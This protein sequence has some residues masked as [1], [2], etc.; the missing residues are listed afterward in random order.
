[1]AIAAADTKGACTRTGTTFSCT[2]ATDT[3]Q[4]DPKKPNE[5][6]FLFKCGSSVSLI[7]TADGKPTGTTGQ[8]SVDVEVDNC[9]PTLALTDPQK[10][11]LD[12]R[13]YIGKFDVIG[14]VAEK[15]F[16][17]AS[18]T[19]RLDQEGAEP[20]E[21]LKL[22]KPGAFKHTID[23]RFD[24]SAHWI[25][26]LDSTDAVGNGS[27]VEA[28]VRIVRQPTF[29]GNS[30]ESDKFLQKINDF[31]IDQFDPEDTLLDALVATPEGLVLRRGLPRADDPAVHGGAFDPLAPDIAL[32]AT[33]APLLG[34]DGKIVD[35]AELHQAPYRILVG[36]VKRLFVEDLD[37]D[38]D[39]DVIA[40]GIDAVTG[41][42][43]WALLAWDKT[44]KTKDG[45]KT[46]RTFKVLDKRSLPEEPLSAAFADLDKDGAKDL[47]VGAK[48]DN[49]GLSVVRLQPQ[50]TCKAKKADAAVPCGELD[51][52]TITIGTIF[53]ELEAPVVNKGVTQ[54]TSIAVGDYYKDDKSLPDVCVGE[55]TR[56]VI[57]CYRN[58][59]VDGRLEQ[60]QDGLVLPDYADTT[61]IVPVEWSAPGTN[62]GPDLIV[63]TTKG[64]RWLKGKHDGT[65]FYDPG[66]Y[67]QIVGVNATAVQVAPIGPKGSPYLIVTAAGREVTVLP[68]LASDSS[69]MAMCFR[70]WVLGGAVGAA[71]AVDLDGNGAQD[72]VSIDAAPNGVNVAWGLP[73]GEYA[74]PNAYH[75]CARPENT[76]ALAP[77]ELADFSFIDLGTDKFPELL[78]IGKSSWSMQP[79]S[80]GTCVLEG[81]GVIHKPAWPISIYMNFNKKLLPTPRGGE[82]A[83]YAHAAQSGASA[84]CGQGTI[85]SFGSVSALRA[86]DLT[87]DKIADLALTRD[88]A[89]Y[90]IGD[91]TVSSPACGP[92]EWAA[93]NEVDN[94]FGVDSPPAPAAG[95]PELPKQLCCKNFFAGDEKKTKP[96]SGYGSGA[97]LQRASLFLFQGTDKDPFA[98][99]PA[100][101]VSQPC[102]IKPQV[103]LAAG[104]N[105]IGIATGDF[106]SDKRIDLA[107]VMK[108]SG[109]VSNEKQ[110]YLEARV[111]YFRSELA[112][113]KLTVQTFKHVPQKDQWK[114]ID[115]KSG[116][117]AKNIDVTYR[118]VEQ[119]PFD[120]CVAPWGPGLKLPS[121]FT[122]NG[123]LGHV[124]VVRSVGNL[125]T[126]VAKEFVI[127]AGN[128]TCVCDDF[129]GDAWMDLLCA[130]PSSI[131]FIRGDGTLF[132]P[133][134]T[135]TEDLEAD[136]GALLSVD[137]NKDDVPDIAYID[138]QAAVVEF[139]LGTGAP[140]SDATGP[141]SAAFIH[142][143]GK[144]RTANTP[145]AL[146]RADVDG[147][148]CFDL[149]VRS[150]LGV[151]LLRNRL[152]AKLGTP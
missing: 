96:L 24:G 12:G 90:D 117:W 89:D 44:V 8:A 2:F 144:L 22:T 27:R 59:G 58:A 15:N 142:Y 38:A 13:V 36:N 41:P 145:L 34:K 111:R 150:K 99:G 30:D 92:C 56:P 109:S 107:T 71:K 147:D 151:T 149:A 123:K 65:F 31:A 120:V 53:K 21:L 9:G 115:P 72:I 138:R 88:N 140:V 78:V 108:S 46:V 5:K 114:W 98:V 101:S 93:T 143:E 82:F 133:K 52:A 18:L 57:S 14:S 83:P 104:R 119:D 60:A 136:V 116:L 148:G 126:D 61:L 91:D 42:T 81:G 130:L 106:D 47:I 39:L 134:Q 3:K 67:R 32:D 86:V 113:G 75:L 135:L 112:G 97:P 23:R 125:G 16:G 64:L 80:Q 118:K 10:Q 79:G 127:G 146:A 48:S 85:S 110:Q 45:E 137:V 121:V 73:D 76:N 17:S 62:D 33:G 7:V 66:S 50:P 105:P 19:V 87:D 124:S 26:A 11:K 102:V 37:G 152:C 74:A 129:D 128:K 29:L 28:R 70:S 20:V 139:Y 55:G 131:G 49:F 40:V 141:G 95:E 1:M 43:A 54:V 69:H 6:T 103:A 122:I 132:K 77:S 25:V 51:L 35:N 4:D 94:L 84:D 68:V 63:A 100:C